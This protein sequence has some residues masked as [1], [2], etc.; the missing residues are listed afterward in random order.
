MFRAR[1]TREHRERVDRGDLYDPTAIV[2][3]S[4]TVGFIDYSAPWSVSMGVNLSRSSSGL[5]D[6]RTI[7]TL[8]VN[9]LNA[10]LTQN[11]S[12]TGS[13]GLDL[14][15]GEITSTRLGLRRDLHCWELA[16]NWQP[17]GLTRLFSVSLYVKSGFLRDFLRL[18]VPNSTVRTGSLGQ[19]GGGGPF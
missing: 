8:D 11:W 14:T 1:E 4:A 2:P 12:L 9:Q 16:V 15:S 5:G 18:D 19:F 3:Q 10:R 7:A 13:T 6:P 17:I